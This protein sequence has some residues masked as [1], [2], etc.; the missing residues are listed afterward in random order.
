VK[1]ALEPESLSLAADGWRDAVSSAY[2]SQKVTDINQ[3]SKPVGA[4]EISGGSAP[5]CNK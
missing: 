2:H 3:L 5:P 4:R 1:K